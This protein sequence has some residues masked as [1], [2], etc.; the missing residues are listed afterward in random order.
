[1]GH[2]AREGMQE[3]TRLWDCV[4]K[5]E[6]EKA[7]QGGSRGC[8]HPCPHSQGSLVTHFCNWVQKWLFWGHQ[9]V[10]AGKAAEESVGGSGFFQDLFLAVTQLWD[11]KLYPLWLLPGREVTSLCPCSPSFRNAGISLSVPW[12]LIL[13]SAV[14]SHSSR[15]PLPWHSRPLSQVALF[16]N[17]PNIA[18]KSQARFHGL[19]GALSEGCPCSF[20]N[21]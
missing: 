10:Q 2:K 9:N 1:M 11:L 12:D 4:W 7:P 5:R 18:D 21:S 16:S 17:C 19:P 20:P 8:P 14:G 3:R 6:L 13:L 15:S